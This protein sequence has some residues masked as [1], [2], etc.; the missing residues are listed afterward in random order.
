M[1]QASSPRG[2][3]WALLVICDDV[4]EV[5]RILHGTDD[6]LGHSR[7]SFSMQQPLRT[8]SAAAAG[9]SLHA[10]VHVLAPLTVGTRKPETLSGNAAAAA[11]SMVRRFLHAAQEALGCLVLHLERALSLYGQQEYELS[12]GGDRRDLCSAVPLRLGT[13]L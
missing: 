10:A 2:S 6:L 13:V 1:T 7:Y 4:R 5:V 9:A 8:A 12:A 3:A 11:V